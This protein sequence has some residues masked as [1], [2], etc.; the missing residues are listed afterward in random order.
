MPLPSFLDDVLGGSVRLLRQTQTIGHRASWASCEASLTSGQLKSTGTV[1]FMK[2]KRP[3][4]SFGGSRHSPLQQLNAGA[5]NESTTRSFLPASSPREAAEH[6]RP[7]KV[8]RSL[9][10]LTSRVT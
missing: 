2:R 8:A 7:A 1:F 5:F 4:I 6:S 3:K 9:F 10:P